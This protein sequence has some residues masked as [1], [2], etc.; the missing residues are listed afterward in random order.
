MNALIYLYDTLICIMRF[1]FFYL[2]IFLIS[3]KELVV[4]SSVRLL[5]S[6]YGFQSSFFA[7][8]TLLNY[9]SCHIPNLFLLLHVPTTAVYFTLALICRRFGTWTVAKQ[10]WDRSRILL[11]GPVCNGTQ[12]I[13]WHISWSS[14]NMRF[15]RFH[16]EM[17]GF[18]FNSTILW[19]PKRW[20]RPTLEPIRQLDAFKDGFQVSVYWFFFCL[21]ISFFWFHLTAIIMAI[22][23]IYCIFQLNQFW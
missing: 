16:A 17:S 7:W 13:G 1:N 21:S 15:L 4:L 8:S 19:D 12:V 23:S 9:F 20:H 11:E 18:A 10:T 3:H 14:S 2:F 6:L 22:A 5:S